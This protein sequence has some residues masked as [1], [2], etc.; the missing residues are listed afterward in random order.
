MDKMNEK[1]K[2]GSELEMEEDEVKTLK[3]QMLIVINAVNK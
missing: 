1:K 3:E 2:E